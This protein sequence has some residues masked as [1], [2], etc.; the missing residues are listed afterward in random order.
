MISAP[1]FR[2]AILL[3]CLMV[4]ALRAE[5]VDNKTPPPPTEIK[6]WRFEA[7]IDSRR[8]ATLIQGEEIDHVVTKMGEPRRRS[9]KKK[10]PTNQELGYVR[11]VLGPMLQKETRT[12]DGAFAIRSHV[13]F[14]DEITLIFKDG[15][16][17][18]VKTYRTR[19]DDSGQDSLPP[20]MR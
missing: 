6:T 7:D 20:F 16:L 18:N 11:K 1:W 14:T 17:Q 19:S 5:D 15:R 10:D 4:T 2:R 3:P 8:S 12:R 9:K 13:I